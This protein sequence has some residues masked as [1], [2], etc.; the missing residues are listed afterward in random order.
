MTRFDGRVGL[1]RA[2]SVSAPQLSDSV[3]VNTALVLVVTLIAPITP[4]AL[5]AGPLKVVGDAAAPVA[6][7]FIKV[8]MECVP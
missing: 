2:R 1:D 5:A 3:P 7:E 4:L 6:T 8:V